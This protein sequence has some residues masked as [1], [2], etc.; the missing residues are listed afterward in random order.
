M[1]KVDQ[2]SNPS[3]AAQCAGTILCTVA[4]WLAAAASLAGY[5]FI[6]G[7]LAIILGIRLSHRGGRAG[8]ILV[9]ASILLMAAGLMLNGMIYDYL[10]NAVGV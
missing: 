7:S 4:G 8:M 3:R 2:T 6:F 10:K 5:P 9:A 1:D